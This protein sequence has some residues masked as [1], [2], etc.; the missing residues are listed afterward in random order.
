[1]CNNGFAEVVG[2]LPSISANHKTLRRPYYTFSICSLYK[3]FYWLSF[4]TAFSIKL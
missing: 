4:V 3:P 2:F 1:M